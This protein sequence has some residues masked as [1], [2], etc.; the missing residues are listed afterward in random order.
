MVVGCRL[1]KS[2]HDAVRAI[3]I[4]S[5][6]PHG[7]GPPVHIGDPDTI[8]IEDYHHPDIFTLIHVKNL[9]HPE[10]VDKGYDLE[11]GEVRMFWGCGVTP[12]LVAMAAKV[13]FMITHKPAHL[14]ISDKHC[15]EWAIL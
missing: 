4:A 2:A 13:P 12:Q 3:Q 14:F 15:E 9:Q 1:F 11:P 8:G 6:Y 7:H 10:M 5:R